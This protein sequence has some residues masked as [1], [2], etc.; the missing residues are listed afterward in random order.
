LL[1]DYFTKFEGLNQSG[2][3]D[4]CQ[5]I[6]NYQFM[7]KTLFLAITFFLPLNSILSNSVIVCGEILNYS[8]KKIILTIYPT[9][10]ITI[11]EK[12]VNLSSSTSEEGLFYFKLEN[13][14]HVLYENTLKIGS[15][16]I[17]ML[18]APGDSINIAFNYRNKYDS[19]RF[20]GINATK[21]Y[22]F[23]AYLC[24]LHDS[25]KTIDFDINWLEKNQMLLGQYASNYNIDENSVAIINQYLS[26]DYYNNVFAPYNVNTNSS[27]LD[28]FNLNNENLTWYYLYYSAISGYISCKEGTD[29]FL[30]TEQ[31]LER[32]FFFSEKYLSGQIKENYQAYILNF[33]LSYITGDFKKSEKCH[34]IINEFLANCKNDYVRK[35]I[36]ELI[37]KK[38]ML[39]YVTCVTSYP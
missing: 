22:F 28:K 34:E 7:I 14:D 6:K 38:R 11:N 39:K 29:Y 21:N 31:Y 35:N 4:V 13:I 18:F 5:H 16:K 9:D 1:K 2:F 10:P 37:R 19:I 8:N 32:C 36:L 3:P 17:Y 25:I 20:S 30:T 24:N 33:N 12:S 23:N 15:R 27:S 26:C